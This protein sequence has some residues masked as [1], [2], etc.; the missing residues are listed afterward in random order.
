[1]DRATRLWEAARVRVTKP[2][3]LQDLPNFVTGT[4]L[5]CHAQI[6][7]LHHALPLFLFEAAADF[8]SPN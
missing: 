7:T 2:W 1:M 5:T 6:Q 3:S 8:Q 4:V